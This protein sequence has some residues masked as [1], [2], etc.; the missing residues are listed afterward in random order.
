[1]PLVD[2]YF[3]YPASKSTD[4][5][6]IILPDVIG[7]RFT[8]VQLIADQFAANGYFT[9]IPDIFRGDAIPLQRPEGFSIDEWRKGH[10]NEQVDPIVEATIKELKE[11]YGAKKIGTV[12]YCFGAKGVVRYLKKGV[13]D[14]GYVAHP[15]FVTE[16]EIKAVEGPLSIA[17]AETDGIF[18]PE[19]RHATEVIL[20][21]IKVPYQINL[22]SGAQH[23]FAVRGDL[24][25]PVVKY[26]KE[27][28]FL[29]A[30]YWFNEHLKI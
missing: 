3:A 1:M 24:S 9:V 19:K 12:G 28:A 7:N 13:T 17:A 2:T 20:Q 15:S 6:I 22:Y 4:K 14:A 16:D 25:V 11:T 27:Q 10:T 5:A 18:P 29:Q 23:G 21:E 30:V 26:A 8:N